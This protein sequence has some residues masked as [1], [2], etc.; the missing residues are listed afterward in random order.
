MNDVVIWGCGGHAREVSLL[1]G[2]LGLS[3]IGFLD[4]RP[5]MKGQVVDDVPILGVLED[6]AALRGRLSVICA[7]V[8]DPALRRRFAAMTGEAGFR[9]SDPVVHPQ[10]SLS[11]RSSLGPGT[12][13]CA[14]AT[15]TVNVHL[16]Q[17]VVVNRNAT[18]GHDVSVADFVTISPAVAISG[19]VIV[20]E[21]V[22]IG[23]NAAIREKIRI[24]AWSIIG[25]GAFVRANVPPRVLVAGV[26]AVVKRQLT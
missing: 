1:C 8:G 17:H 9:I 6:I 3:V 18:I 2:S 21:G 20:E 25:G 13:V 11:P 23:T 14:G 22:Y 4:E 12:V 10:V 7:G 15:L 16:G 24:G 19:N 26:P 5:E